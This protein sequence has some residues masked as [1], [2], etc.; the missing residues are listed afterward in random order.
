MKILIVPGAN[1]LS[2]FIKSVSIKKCFEQRGHNVQIAISKQYKEFASML[3]ED[4]FIIPNIQEVD[5]SSF[6]T[7]NWFKDERN[8]CSCVSAERRLIKTFEPEMIIGIFNFTIKMSAQLEGIPFYTLSC[9][10]MLSKSKTVLG[11]DQEDS[12][13]YTQKQYIDSFF[14]YMTVKINRVICKYALPKINDIRE[15]LEGEI[16]F[17]WDFPEFMPIDDFENILHVGPI[18]M[19]SLNRHSETV[20]LIKNCSRKIAAVSFGT[21]SFSS[22]TIQKL[23]QILTNMNFFVVIIGGFQNNSECVCKT[24]KNVVYINHAPLPLILEKSSI[25]IT[26]GGQMSLFEAISNRVPSLVIPFQPEQDHNGSCLE[27]I[28]CGKRFFK[29]DPFNFL[30]E[31]Y[32]KKFN[33]LSDNKITSTISKQ[34]DDSEVKKNLSDYSKIIDGYDSLKNISNKLENI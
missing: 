12:G 25:L 15:C 17:L 24:K 22:K 14:Q 4:F 29:A 11:F 26:H 1:A 31:Y 5:Y 32:I 10:C 7:L 9:G 3:D 27:N 2:H 34:L 19:I 8:I 23:I 28:G 6:P 21:C 18:P 30:P 33:T 20:D 13:Y 16:T